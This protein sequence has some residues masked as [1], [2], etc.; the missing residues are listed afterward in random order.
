[1][2]MA[3]RIQRPRAVMISATTNVAAVMIAM[4]VAVGEIATAI[5]I[6]ATVHH[7]KIASQFSAMTMS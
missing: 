2:M 6:T 5:A 3:K 1:M 7:A 4:I